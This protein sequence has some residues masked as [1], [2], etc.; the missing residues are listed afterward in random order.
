M[1]MVTKTCEMREA[2]RKAEGEGSSKERQW[3]IVVKQNKKWEID[4]DLVI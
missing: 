1:K 2:V 4:L 3:S